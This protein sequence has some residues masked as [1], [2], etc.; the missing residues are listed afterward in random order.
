MQNAVTQPI[1]GL[2]VSLRD[3]QPIL[4]DDDGSLEINVKLPATLVLIVTN[5]KGAARRIN[6]R[7]FNAGTILVSSL[8]RLMEDGQSAQFDIMPIEIGTIR[9][10]FDGEAA[11]EAGIRIMEK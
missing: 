10:W 11:V 8:T 7:H 6:L 4:L 9:M 5:R 3:G 2:E 1:P